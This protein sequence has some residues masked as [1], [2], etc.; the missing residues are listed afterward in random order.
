MIDVAIP[1]IM[2]ALNY[3][4]KVIRAQA[5]T[6][7]FQDAFPVISFIFMCALLPALL[8]RRAGAKKPAGRS[9]KSKATSTG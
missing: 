2:G 8:L 9:P 4:G 7:G 6:F 1:S 3:L 5:L